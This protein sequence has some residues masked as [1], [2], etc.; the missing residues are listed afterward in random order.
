MGVIGSMVARILL[1]PFPGGDHPPV[2]PE[3]DET[4]LVDFPLDWF[5]R[6]FAP[7]ARN[8]D[9]SASE[10]GGQSYCTHGWCDSQPAIGVGQYVVGVCLASVSSA[11]NQGLVQTLFN[12]ILGPKPQVRIMLINNLQG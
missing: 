3:I 7:E 8:V 12:K 6:S 10:G 4:T 5:A 11:F 1:Y 2:K 9:C